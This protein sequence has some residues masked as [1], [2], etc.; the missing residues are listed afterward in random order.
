VETQ[1]AHIAAGQDGLIVRLDGY[2]EPSQAL[3]VVGHEA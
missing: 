1:I 2:E 3:A